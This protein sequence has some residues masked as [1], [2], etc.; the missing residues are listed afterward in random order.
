[1]KTLRLATSEIARHSRP[2]NRL[3]VIFLL[4]VPTLYGALYLWSNWDPYGDLDQVPVAVVNEDEPVTV[5]GTDIAA[6]EEL[7]DKMLEEPVFGWQVTDAKDAADGLESGRYY[8]T[9]TIPEDFSANLA[10]GADGTPERATIDMRRNDANGFVVGIMAETVQKQLHDQVNSAATTAYFESV[11][12]SLADLRDGIGQAQ[13]GAHDLADGL[14]DARSGSAELADG[15]VT[16]ADGAQELSAGS[17]QVAGGTQQIAD[18]INPIA[19]D[20]VPALPQITEDAEELSGAADELSGLVSA[21]ADSLDSRVEEV[22]AA[23]AKI[24]EDHPDV[25]DSQAYQDLA[26]AADA[27]AGRTNEIASTTSDIHDSADRVHSSAQAAV[28]AVPDIQTKIRD[29][30]SDVNTLNDGAHQVSAGLAELAPRLGDARDGAGE[31]AGGLED[32]ADGSN[33]L[34]DGLDEIIAQVP[35]LDR[36]TREANAQILGDPTDVDLE[37]DNPAHV[38]GRGLAPFFFAISLWVFGIVVFLVLR[39]IS[40]RALASQANS[41]RVLLSGWLPVAGI[42]LAGAYLLYAVSWLGLGLDPVHPG[43]SLLVITVTVLLFTLIAHAARTGLGLVGSAVLLV[44]LMLQLTSSAG[45]YPMETLP[46]PLKAIHPYLP[47]TYVIDALR[48]TFSGGSSAKLA[49]D[50]TVLALFAAA[51][52][53]LAFWVI[54]RKRTWSLLSVHPPLAE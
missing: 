19:N 4:I 17:E 25:A 8:I 44:L 7:V 53:A 49:G 50:L 2:L 54:R 29:A 30:Q 13:D 41:L 32:A 6:G 38:Y 3:A 43:M 35:A 22:D 28:T 1:M 39:P 14:G 47:M 9:I 20:L 51:M 10:S 21:G 12:G 26:A 46:A 34:A 37:V 45:I 42:G 5:D 52:F 36:D 48:I 40:G 24:A 11:Y 16:A 18:V 33:D 31:L 23:I 15:L 27:L